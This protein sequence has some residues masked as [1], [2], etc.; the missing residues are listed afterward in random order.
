MSTR[1]HHTTTLP[2]EYVATPDA[3]AAI[4]HIESTVTDYY[5]GVEVDVTELVDKALS[6]AGLTITV[7]SG[8]NRACIQAR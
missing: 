6:L 5:A 1:H 7:D 4:A 3:R 8:H 2:G